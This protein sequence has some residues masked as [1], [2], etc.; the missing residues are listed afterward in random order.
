MVML[1]AERQETAETVALV[2]GSSRM[3]SQAPYYS[4]LPAVIYEG[5]IG[6]RQVQSMPG[7]SKY[8]LVVQM[9]IAPEI[10]REFNDWYDQEHVPLLMKVPG[11]KASRRFRLI[12]G[13]APKYMTIYELEGPTVFDRSEHQITHTTEWYQ[14]LRPRFENFSALLYEQLYGLSRC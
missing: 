7:S 6:F 13:S 2:A 11:W 8:L 10:E 1:E 4:C 3:K 14:R 12:R 9:D 5:F